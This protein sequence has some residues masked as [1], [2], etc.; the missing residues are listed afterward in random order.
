MI[1]KNCKIDINENNIFLNDKLN[2]EEI[3][4]DLSKLIIPCEESFVFSV[5]ASWGSGKTTFIKLWQ[6]YL[7]KEHQVNSIYFSA[8]EDDFSKDP[9]VSILGELSSYID[10]NFKDDTEIADRWAELKDVGGKIIRRGLPALIKGSTAGVIDVDRGIESAIGAMTESVAKELIDS[11]AKDK[12]VTIE[13]R[14]SMNQILEQIDSEK[15][16]IIFIDELDRCRPLYAIELLER[17]KHVFG[18]DK[19]I[20][21][22]S[23]DKKQ[24]SESIKS[25]YGDIDT[26]NYLRRFIDLEYNLTNS[27]IDIFCDVLYQKFKL[28]EILQAKGIKTEF[29]DFHHLNMMKKLVSTFKLSLRQIEQVFTKLHII[30]STIQP[31]LYESH[32]RVFVFF[33]M[34]KAYNS[35]LYYRFICEGDGIEQIKKL[36]LSSVQ[37]DDQYRDVSVMLEAILDSAAKTDSE[38]SLLL[39][40]KEKELSELPDQTSIE[41]RKLDWYINLLKHSPDQWGDYKLN[42]LVQTVI[43]KI[44]FVDR[45]NLEKAE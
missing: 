2:R 20:F 11:Y 38:Y 14:S 34:L 5:N 1:F 19:L 28:N 36:V 15:P 23:I 30:F 24:L 35:E 44:E 29:G 43:K 17:I 31:R 8:W 39:K 45:F 33:E 3:I 37:N 26:D 12:A 25:Q 13:F 4:K 18:I 40:K 10:E 42:K 27:D 6:A 16:F 21:V 7:K 22:L 41:Y 9:L 32:F